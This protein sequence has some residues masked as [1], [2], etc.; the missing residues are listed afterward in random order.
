MT[1]AGALVLFKRSGD[2]VSP[3]SLNLFKNTIGIGLLIVTLIVMGEGFDAIA[4]HPASDIYILILSGILGIA[5]A[6][7]VFFYALNLCGVGVISIVD[8]T[9]SPFTIFFSALLLG[10]QLNVYH[11]L[12][13]A[14]V[15]GSVAISSRHTPPANRTRKQLLRGIVLGASAMAMMALGIVMAKP[16]IDLQGFPLIWATLIRLLFGSLA[17][18]LI[19]TASPNRRK[20]WATFKP[21]RVWKFS[22]PGSILGAYLSMLF[23]MA[24]YKYTDASVAAILNQTSVVFALILA[25]LFLKEPFNRRK[26][27]AVALALSGIITIVL[28]AGRA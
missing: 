13:G 17:L 12:G 23:W 8:C 20:I 1:W 11:Y 14:M 16:V 10:E 26:L 24:G 18:G 6:D 2:S 19:A 25:A 15:L 27:L 22:L 3:L 5:I 21:S 4:E 28:L 9:Y 7:T